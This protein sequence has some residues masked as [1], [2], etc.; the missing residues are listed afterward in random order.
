[1][2]KS[3]LVKELTAIKEDTREVSQNSQS[4]EAVLECGKVC[5]ALCCILRDIEEEGLTDD[6]S[7]TDSTTQSY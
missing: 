5:R 3:R 7:R 2:T 1:M 4:L 6:Q